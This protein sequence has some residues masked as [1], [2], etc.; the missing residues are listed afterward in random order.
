MYLHNIVS[1]QDLAPD[2]LFPTTFKWPYLQKM[3]YFDSWDFSFWTESFPSNSLSLSYVNESTILYFQLPYL[4]GLNGHWK[5]IPRHIWECVS[6][7]ELLS[8]PTSPHLLG[9]GLCTPLGNDS[10]ERLAKNLPFDDG[11]R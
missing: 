2:S 11:F 4:V 8:F 7:G 9:L 6:V 1:G 10:A 5:S 3:G